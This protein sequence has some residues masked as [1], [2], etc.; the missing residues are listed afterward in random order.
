MI[1]LPT[2]DEERAAMRILVAIDGSRY[3]EAALERALDLSSR[4]AEPAELTLIHVA[5][6][7][8]P[9]AAAAVGAEILES[10][11]QHERDGALAH[12]RERLAAA[13]RRA[14]EITAVGSPG[15]LIAEH[16]DGGGFDLVVMGSHGHGA[17]AGLVLGSTVS[18]VLSLSKVPLLIVR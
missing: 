4:L 6:P 17:L 16:A 14:A 12:A 10:W 11:Y 9:R 5:L 1:G 3:G 18:A 15:R 7:A 2:H 8:P 13:G